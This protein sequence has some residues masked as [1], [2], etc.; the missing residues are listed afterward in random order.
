[1][2]DYRPID[3][4]QHSM[5]ELLAM[6]RAPVVLAGLDAEAGPVHVEG[7]VVDVLTQAGA[8]YLVLEN[9]DGHHRVRLD[10]IQS[11]RDPDRREIWRQQSGV[12]D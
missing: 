4:D 12:R 8:E 1:M 9:A 5:L 10:R 3:C 2:T 11:L 7:V 6:R